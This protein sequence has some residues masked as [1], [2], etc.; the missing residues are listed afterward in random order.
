M[1]RRADL[2]A[3]Q[4]SV[5]A[6][7]CRS[8][9]ALRKVMKKSGASRRRASQRTRASTAHIRDAKRNARID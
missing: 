1:T 3:R 4:V 8:G 5:A 9:I 7:R 6:R 2:A